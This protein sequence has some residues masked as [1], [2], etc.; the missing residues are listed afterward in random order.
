MKI[1]I[2]LNVN[3]KTLI[4]V[5]LLLGFLCLLTALYFSP[6][7]QNNRYVQAYK[8][9][10]QAKKFPPNSN[11]YLRYMAIADA[12]RNGQKNYTYTPNFN[13]MNPGTKP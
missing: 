9:E 4:R 11:E 1:K 13:P 7:V 6:F 8:I 5:I 12:I 3:Q 2:R 10:Q